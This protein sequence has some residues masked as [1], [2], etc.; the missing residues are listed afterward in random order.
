MLEWKP[1][2]VISAGALGVLAVRPLGV[3]AVWLRQLRL[4][5]RLATPG[6]GE[7]KVTAEA[8]HR[9]LGCAPPLTRPPAASG[10]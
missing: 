7:T 10:R 2:L 6:V 4:V 1:R 9:A 5:S 3:S 8:A